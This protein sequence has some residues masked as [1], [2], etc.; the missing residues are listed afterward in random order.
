M[1]LHVPPALDKNLGEVRIGDLPPSAHFGTFHELHTLLQQWGRQNGVTF[2]KKGS[3]NPRN[4][5]GKRVATN[6]RLW[7][8]HSKERV[9]RSS[10][11]RN[12]NSRLW[13]CPF[14]VQA[15]CKVRLNNMWEYSVVSGREKHNHEPSRDTLAHPVHRHRT[16]AQNK[17]IRELSA[18]P[19]IEA[20]EIAERLKLQYPEAL[21]T[22]RDI[23]NER[24]IARRDA[25]ARSHHEPPVKVPA[26]D[27]PKPGTPDLNMSLISMNS[28]AIN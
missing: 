3:S 24:Q 4:I 11:I 15:S 17:A 19:G 2:V 5:N 26:K 8:D 7:C 14:R 16:E 22:G 28:R 18:L 6:V 20:C 10:G 9:S 12:H 13:N 25:L 23:E 27:K 21:V 1:A